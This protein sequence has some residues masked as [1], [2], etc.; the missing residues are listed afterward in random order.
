VNLSEMIQEDVIKVGLE[1]T[2]KW[3]AIEE[4]IDV[5]V[6]AHELRL[7]DRAEVMEAVVTREESMSTGLEHGLAVPHGAVDCVN[8][9]VASLGVSRGGIPFQSADGS[10]AYLVALLVI[11]KGS[12][13]RHVRTLA[14]IARLASS[15]DLRQKIIAAA[16]PGEVFRVIYEQEVAQKQELP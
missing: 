3:E 10:P 13:Q 6:N 8:D 14:A 15:A 7:T 16:T 2:N 11:P 1:A 9:I 5:L 12:F 4:L